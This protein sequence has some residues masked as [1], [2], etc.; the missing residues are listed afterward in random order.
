MGWNASRPVPWR[1]FVKEGV[2]FAVGMAIVLTVFDNDIR[3]ASYLG[4]VIGAAMYVVFVAILAKFGYVRATLR[5]VR[6]QVGATRSMSDTTG[7]A[8]SARPRPAPTSRTGGAPRR[9]RR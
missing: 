9:R 8:S 7:T 4:L 2:V 1:R 5:D 3:P 6:A